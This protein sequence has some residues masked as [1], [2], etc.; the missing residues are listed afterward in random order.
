MKFLKILATVLAPPKTNYYTVPKL[1]YEQIWKLL[2]II[3]EACKYSYS[4]NEII[5]P[6]SNAF[7]Y[8]EVYF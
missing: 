3:I 8:F 2:K 5:L 4:D 7:V 1:K 6:F